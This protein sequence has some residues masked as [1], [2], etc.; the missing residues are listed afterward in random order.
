MSIFRGSKRE[1]GPSDYPGQTSLPIRPP[2]HMI[3][4]IAITGNMKKC[5]ALN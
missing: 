3:I 5:N 1:P 2:R 4:L